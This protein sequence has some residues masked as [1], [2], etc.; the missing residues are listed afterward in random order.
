MGKIKIYSVLF[1]LMAGSLACRKTVGLLTGTS[2]LTIVNAVNG[3]NPLVTDF[4]ALNGKGVIEATLQ[5]FS[6]ANEIPYMSFWQSGSYIGPTSLSL[7]QI[8]DTLAFLWSGTLTLPVG[9]LHTLYL[10]GDTSHIDTAFEIDMIP[11]YPN[12][13]SVAGVRFIN[14][15]SGSQPMSVNIQGNPPT[16]TEFS[17][18]SYKQPA[19]FKT[20]IANSNAPGFYNFEIRDI[21]TDSLLTTYTW[22]Y[23]LFENQT[24]VIAGSENSNSNYP[25]IA[26]TVNN[27]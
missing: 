26:F 11:Y 15:T 19:N 3:S 27:Y 1:I 22:N 4:A 18:L 2:S 20:Y 14:L 9:S 16:Q 23:T 7:C 17:N 13:D 6:T 24:I 12:S 8:S 21:A 5:Y 25:I 10:C